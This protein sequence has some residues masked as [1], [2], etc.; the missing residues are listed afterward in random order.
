MNEKILTFFVACTLFISCATQETRTQNVL[1]NG[2]LANAAHD[3]VYLSKLHFDRITDT[4]TIVLDKDGNF[5]IEIDLDKTEFF[6]LVHKGSNFVRLLIDIGEQIE[7]TAD[8]SN[9]PATFYAKGSEGTTLLQQIEKRV[10]KANAYVDSL[11]QIVSQ[12]KDAS[13]FSQIFPALDSAYHQNIENI[14]EEFMALINDNLSSLAA[15]TAIYQTVA[16]QSL[17]NE[18]NH[19]ELFETLS[20]HIIKEHPDNSFAQN[21]FNR[22]NEMKRR[23]ME[24]ESIEKNLQKGL[25]APDISLIDVDGQVLSLS[26]FKGNVLLL[27]FWDSHC[28]ICHRENQ[29]LKNIH[30]KYKNKG[31]AVLSV[32][33]DVDKN[34][35]LNYL[36]NHKPEWH[37][38]WLYENDNTINNANIT[39]KYF[40]DIIPVAHLINKDGVLI[41]LNIKSDKLE[42]TLKQLFE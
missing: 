42:E 11:Q 37:Q 40:L 3:T 41:D 32:S 13:D 1:I 28:Q 25:P 34:D 33:V 26:S 23:K 2:Q 19:Y 35:W 18:F 36:A 15:V 30:R 16:N 5:S 29:N 20:T 38:A 8:I 39:T 10:Q 24:R 12:K 21:I 4:D 31:F 27:K 22:F 7:L 17:F 14:R 9:I 6:V